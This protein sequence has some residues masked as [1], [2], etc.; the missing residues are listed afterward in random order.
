[1]NEREMKAPGPLTTRLKARV[2][3]TFRGE[4]WLTPVGG[5][6]QWKVRLREEVYAVD[7]VLVPG[8]RG[9]A[10]EGRAAQVFVLDVDGL[11]I[12]AFNVFRLSTSERARSL[13][14]L[15]ERYPSASIAQHD[16]ALADAEVVAGAVSDERHAAALAYLAVVM[17]WE[18]RH[19]LPVVI[20]GKRYECTHDGSPQKEW[21]IEVKAV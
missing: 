18:E 5:G 17:S 8:E 15:K 12:V 4:R 14:A 21:S 10:A 3:D 6:R 16:G 13:A 19:V 9:E 20:D 1:V 7:R 2:A 11:E